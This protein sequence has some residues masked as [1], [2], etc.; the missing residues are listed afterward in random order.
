MAKDI[1]GLVNS[2]CLVVLEKLERFPRGVGDHAHRQQHTA[3]KPAMGKWKRERRLKEPFMVGRLKREGI[4]WGEGQKFNIPLG[5]FFF[6]RLVVLPS[7]C[8]VPCLL[9]KTWVHY[10]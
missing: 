5:Y 9:D 8:C 6:S 3:S 1:Q 2:K 10:T 4:F 7:Y